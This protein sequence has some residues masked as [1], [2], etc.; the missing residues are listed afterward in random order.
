MRSTPPPNVGWAGRLAARPAKRHPARP[1]LPTGF[2]IHCEICEEMAALMKTPATERAGAA[3]ADCQPASRRFH[4]FRLCASCAAPARSHHPAICGASPRKKR[5]NSLP[6][7]QLAH[8]SWSAA[9]RIAV[10]PVKSSH[11]RTITS[12]YFDRV[13]SAARCG[14]TSRPQSAL[15]QNHRTDRAPRCPGGSNCGSPAR[16][17]PPASSSDADRSSAAS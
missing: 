8:N 5:P 10:W 7:I 3:L 13:R 1:A 6:A 2:V 14:L 4:Q 11:R 15:C 12:T 17:A 16:P 9:S